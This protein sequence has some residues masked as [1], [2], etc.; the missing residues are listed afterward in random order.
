MYQTTLQGKIT[1]AYGQ[2]S[3]LNWILY[4]HGEVFIQWRQFFF[5]WLSI[6]SK[7]SLLICIWV[8]WVALRLD[9]RLYGW[10]GVAKRWGNLKTWNQKT[11]TKQRQVRPRRRGRPSERAIKKGKRDRLPWVN[12]WTE[13]ELQLQGHYRQYIFLKFVSSFLC[14]KTEAPGEWDKKKDRWGEGVKVYKSS[15]HTDQ[16]GCSVKRSTI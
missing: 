10:R 2:R 1:L 3:V 6:G 7:G 4:P 13:S 11:K 12:P 16:H 5:F 8:D 15:I 9:S 14:D